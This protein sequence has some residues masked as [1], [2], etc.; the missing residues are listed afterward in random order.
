MDTI[1]KWFEELFERLGFVY[2]NASF[3]GNYL[4]FLDTP[5][6]ENG[7]APLLRNRVVGL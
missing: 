7:I 1:F 5:E 4:A 3:G 6:R 2:K